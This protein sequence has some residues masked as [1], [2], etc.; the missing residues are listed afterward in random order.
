MPNGRLSTE[1]AQIIARA[2]N[3]GAIHDDRVDYWVS[4]ARSGEDISGLD[5]CV[6]ADG[7]TAYGDPGDD[8]AAFDLLYPARTREQHERRVRRERLT[9]SA[10]RAWTDDDVYAALFPLDGRAQ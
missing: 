4:A 5:L 9:A 3:R 7:A 6:G 2:V 10:R 8:E 1:D